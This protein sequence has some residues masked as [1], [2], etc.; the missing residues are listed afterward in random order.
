MSAPRN[1]KVDIGV[2]TV[3]LAIATII[4]AIISNIDNLFFYLSNPISS[5][6]TTTDLN[7][8]NLSIDTVSLE[9]EEIESKLSVRLDDNNIITY[10]HNYGKVE[11]INSHS[12]I[13]F[14]YNTL[15]DDIPIGTIT[16]YGCTTGGWK[17]IFNKGSDNFGFYFQFDENTADTIHLLAA[18]NDSEGC[19]VLPSTAYTYN[20]STNNPEY[21]KIIFCVDDVPFNL[22]YSDS[23]TVDGT[24]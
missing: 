1:W 3:I 10:T 19:H 13:V 6:E 4:A 5:S 17:A 2:A 23:I 12:G 9:T 16:E 21:L 11:L 20:Y 15:F 7:N 14:I 18:Y 22:Q 24:L 8:D